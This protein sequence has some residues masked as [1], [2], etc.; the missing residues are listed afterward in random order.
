[1]KIF[2]ITFTFILFMILLL[3]LKIY[4]NFN[5]SRDLKIEEKLRLKKSADKLNECFDLKNKSK[6]TLNDSMKLIE[7]CLMKYGSD[8]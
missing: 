6:R 5:T 2:R 1:M 8:K 7:Y 4:R 3:G